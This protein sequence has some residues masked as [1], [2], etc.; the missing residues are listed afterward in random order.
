MQLYYYF[1]LI[2]FLVPVYFSVSVLEMKSKSK[3]CVFFVFFMNSV[4]KIF[5]YYYFES[6][7]IYIFSFHYNFNYI[8]VK[9]IT[10]S[11]LETKS[12]SK[13]GCFFYLQFFYEFGFKNFLYGCRFFCRLMFISENIFFPN[14]K[15]HS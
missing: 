9:K 10:F 11:L 5:L 13:K 14:T 4:F 6:D 1:K 12:K 3:K 2:S 15:Q 8:L 7:F